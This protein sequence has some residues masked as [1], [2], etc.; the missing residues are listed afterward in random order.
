MHGRCADRPSVSPPAEVFV[1]FL[2]LGCTSFGGPVAHLGYFR[3]E[4]V[5]KARWLDDATF[6]EV[7]ALCSILPGPTSSQVGI[8]LGARKAGPLGGFLAWL[9]FA[10]PSAILLGALGLFLRSAGNAGSPLHGP[11]FEGALEG[12]GAAAAAV[13]GIA[14]VALARGVLRSRLDVGIALLGFALALGF[15]RFAPT[16][17]WVALLA[18][19]ALGYAFG[20]A[21]R[22]LPARPPA[23][24][25]SRRTGM[26]AGSAFVLL[27]VGLPIVAPPGSY[28]ELFAALYRAG[29]LVFGGGHVVLSFLQSFIGA[30]VS[31]RTF[32]A[33]YGA[34]QAMPG[35][36]FTFAAFLGAVL[37]PNGGLVGAVVAL[38]GIF[39]PSFLLLA[40]VI[41]LWS[42]LRQLPRA[43]QT[44]A[45]LNAGVVGLLAAV[46]V[47]PIA[48]TL[49]RDPVGIALALF[50]LAT[51]VW[52]RFPAW[53]TVACC[54][55][56]GGLI[57]SYASTSGL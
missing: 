41:P 22:S 30:G 49:A 51:L 36:V 14:V 34:T 10:A 20:R 28:L 29:S 7:V 53:A 8:V 17:Q 32:F 57:R 21:P 19:G 33:G 52:L 27:L 6:A 26:I 23:L 24:S 50:A 1:R 25:V 5:E 45:G 56:L 43:S 15:D 54:A 12:L 16:F 18:G 55:L 31:E 44:L 42:A 39:L 47:D 40:A 11:R 4:F 37:E 38:T 46:F 35:P 9:A 3:R 13:V 48:S 2:R